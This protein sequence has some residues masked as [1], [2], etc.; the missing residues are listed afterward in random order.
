MVDVLRRSKTRRH[1]LTKFGDLKRK[2]LQ[3]NY[4]KQMETYRGGTLSKES[5]KERMR[6]LL[7]STMDDDI[8][9]GVPMYSEN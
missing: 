3:Y 8:N 6:S 2:S 7:P 9:S 4:Y 1:K 5:E